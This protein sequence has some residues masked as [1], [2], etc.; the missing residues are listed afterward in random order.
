VVELAQRNAVLLFAKINS[1]NLEKQLVRRMST[2][3]QIE[4]WIT[5]AKDLPRPLTY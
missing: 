1:I 2:Q 5:Q 4:N 3:S